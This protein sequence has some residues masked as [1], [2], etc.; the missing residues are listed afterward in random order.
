MCIYIVFVS[1]LLS[2]GHHLGVQHCAGKN[3][4][5]KVIVVHSQN[6]ESSSLAFHVCNP[7]QESLNNRLL[8][9]HG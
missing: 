1:L 3:I 7:D 2:C 4:Q 9:P 6:I 8:T 5:F